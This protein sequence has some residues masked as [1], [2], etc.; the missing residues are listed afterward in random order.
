M[1]QAYITLVGDLLAQYHA[2]ANNINAA[3]A[4]APAVRAVSLNDYAF[5]LSV[6]LEG[7]LSTAQA[8]GDLESAA[9]LEALVCLCSAGDIPQ[10]FYP[11][12]FAA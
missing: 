2:K 5:R 12:R 7:L 3:T 6:G 11:D 9:N 10:P 1:K 4:I 8:A